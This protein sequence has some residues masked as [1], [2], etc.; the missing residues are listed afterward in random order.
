[1][2]CAVLYSHSP[3]T[4]FELSFLPCTCYFCTNSAAN[5]TAVITV[6]ISLGCR[7]V[8]VFFKGKS[9]V[10]GL[11]ASKDLCSRRFLCCKYC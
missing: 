2:D 6:T 10:R 4:A 8:H 9:D 11:S 1:M 3:F 5:N 7:L